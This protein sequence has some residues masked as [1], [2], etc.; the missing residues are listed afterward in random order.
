MTEA[1][2]DFDTVV[3]GGGIIGLCVSWFL[4]RDGDAIA[5]LDHGYDA[6]STVN[7][8]SLHVQM[9]SRLERL[10][11]KRVLDYE[12][13]LPLYPLAVT[14]WEAV[15][16]ELGKDIGLVVKGGLMVA[17]TQGDLAS[18]ERKSAREQAHGIDTQVISRRELRDVAPYLDEK[19]AGATYC[20]REGKVDPL[21][22]NAA[23]RDRAISSG[24]IIV[25]GVCVDRLDCDKGR[26]H[27]EAGDARY[28]AG[29]VI[30]AAGAGSRTIAMTLGI[31]LPVI[32][33]PLHMNVTE[34]AEPFM[35]H[36]IQHASRPI[37]MKQLGGGHVVIGGG[38]PAGAGLAPRVPTVFVDSLA[39][40][41]ALAAK[42]V[43]GMAEFRVLRSWAG[44]NPTADLIS[45]LGNV[46]AAPNVH[47][48]IPGDAGYTLG[49]CLAQL[50]CEQLAGR[51]PGFPVAAFSPNRFAA[52]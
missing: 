17:E 23:I 39:G 15:A 9:Q 28:T 5:C 51:D 2:S 41:L 19:L 30:V 42:L 22:A 27:I 48:L 52:A 44:I 49:P 31:D 36:L 1:N 37:T 10:F 25:D 4:A 12:K 20:A 34:V 18:L 26:V 8:G 45:I 46:A 50:L 6:G 7:A 38:W 33:E 43:P 3:I 24:A 32:A 11:P 40:N 47:F 29:R 35:S 21:L 16:A 14:T 13:G